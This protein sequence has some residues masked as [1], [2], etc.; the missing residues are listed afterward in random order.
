MTAVVV[1]ILFAVI[2]L[3]LAVALAY[4]PMRLMLSSMAKNIR[5][6][7]REWVQRQRD[8]R[9]KHRESPERRKTTVP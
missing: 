5:T 4:L 8:R 1:S 7:V 3:F 9:A 2:A 6:Q